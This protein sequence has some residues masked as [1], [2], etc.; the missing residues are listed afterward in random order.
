MELYIKRAFIRVMEW[1]NSRP[2]FAGSFV[3]IFVKVLFNNPVGNL[4]ISFP[5]SFDLS[6]SPLLYCEIQSSNIPCTSHDQYLSIVGPVSY[7]PTSLKIV[8]IMLPRSPG[9]H[10]P[11]K[12]FAISAAGINNTE[13]VQSGLSLYIPVSLKPL[14]IFA[15]TYV[16]S[17]PRVKLYF[18]FR[19]DGW[20]PASNV[21]ASIDR[22]SLRL[23]FPPTFPSLSGKQ[24][25]WKAIRGF[26]SSENAKVIV[27]SSHIVSLIGFN[28]FPATE[29]A[30]SL[31]YVSNPGTDGQTAA[32][33]V[34]VVMGEVYDLDELEKN[35]MILGQ[36]PLCM[37]HP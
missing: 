30:F 27:R 1:P 20:I 2:E 23:E 15:N 7:N 4:T 33:S 5:S 28:G 17:Y 3:T 12:L 18:K 16:T 21:E 13:A 26:E 11:I 10:G 29:I 22:I 36:I 32:F 24:L 37:G 8:N 9:Y 25:E 31:G 35:G 14:A 19:T 6:L 34:H